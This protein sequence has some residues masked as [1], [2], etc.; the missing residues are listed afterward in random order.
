[1]V[2]EHGQQR[3]D[4]VL[5]GSRLRRKRGLRLPDLILSRVYNQVRGYLL[6]VAC[7]GD[8]WGAFTVLSLWIFARVICC[9]RF[10]G[11]IDFSNKLRPSLMQPKPLKLI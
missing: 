5:L 6:K 10:Y 11:G 4:M 8:R 3:L 7:C 9:V 2:A 1:M